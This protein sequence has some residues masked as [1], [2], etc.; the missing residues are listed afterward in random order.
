MVEIRPLGKLDTKPLEEEFGRLGTDEV[1][2]TAERF[3]HIRKN[4]PQD[5]EL[6][7]KF[8][9]AAIQSPDIILKDLL[10]ENKHRIYHQKT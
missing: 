5:I 8:G 2:V 10:N 1:V 7:E 9:E 3:E 4:H 6:F